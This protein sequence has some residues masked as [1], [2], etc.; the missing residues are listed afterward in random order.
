M[1]ASGAEEKDADVNYLLYLFYEEPYHI[2]EIKSLDRPGSPDRHIDSHHIAEIYETLDSVGEAWKKNSVLLAVRNREAIGVL[3]IFETN[4]F[5]GGKALPHAA[6]KS[7]PDPIQLSR[8][9]EYLRLRLTIPHSMLRGLVPPPAFEEVFADL[10]NF[11]SVNYLIEALGTGR[12]FAGERVSIVLDQRDSVQLSCGAKHEGEKCSLVRNDFTTVEWNAGIGNE[13]ARYFLFDSLENIL[14]NRIAHERRNK[15]PRPEFRIDVTSRNCTEYA[16]IEIGSQFPKDPDGDLLPLGAFLKM[17]KWRLREPSGVIAVGSAGLHI[18]KQI[19]DR[20]PGASILLTPEFGRY[21]IR[22]PLKK[23]LRCF[24]V[25]SA[26]AE[27]FAQIKPLRSCDRRVDLKE[28]ASFL[29][30]DGRSY[31]IG[32]FHTSYLPIGAKELPDS[33]W[34]TY[35][36]RL[37]ARHAENQVWVE[38]SRHAAIGMAEPPFAQ[39]KVATGGLVRVYKGLNK[40][41]MITKDKLL[42]DIWSAA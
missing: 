32:F 20:L 27:D 2:G 6:A 11:L 25:D 21:V 42:I 24:F 14:K 16:E 18:M 10:R 29:E 39:R 23:P 38:Y 22:V 35:L 8:F 13:L 7:K 41:P 30:Q 4:H 36:L 37:K 40:Q 5:L 31:E 17:K 9:L 3:N 33:N 1:N 12:M 19:A 15:V 26:S 28:L 34:A